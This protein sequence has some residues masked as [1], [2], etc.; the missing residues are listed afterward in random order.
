MPQCAHEGHKALS[1]SFTT[2]KRGQPVTGLVSMVAG[3]NPVY[4]RFEY[5]DPGLIPPRKPG[6][7]KALRHAEAD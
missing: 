4:Q 5:C 7:K 2:E 6:R 1:A 3:W